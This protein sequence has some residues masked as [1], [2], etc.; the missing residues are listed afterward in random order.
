MAAYLRNS[1]AYL[2]GLGIRRDVESV[3]L[4]LEKL[5]YFLGA[6][7]ALLLRAPVQPEHDVFSDRQVGDDSRARR[8]GFGRP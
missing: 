5:E 1:G 8:G 2:L 3:E 4:C 6:S 7:G